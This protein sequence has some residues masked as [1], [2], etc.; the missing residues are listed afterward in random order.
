MSSTQQAFAHAVLSSF[1]LF[2]PQPPFSAP[3]ALLAGS[4]PCSY[5]PT[6][7]LPKVLSE[8]WPVNTGVQ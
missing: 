5:L 1:L 4:L 3:A 7:V 6:Y 2:T 8:D